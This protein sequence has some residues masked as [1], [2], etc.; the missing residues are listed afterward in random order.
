[1]KFPAPTS[2]LLPPGEPRMSKSS[3]VRI[4]CE[5]RGDNQKCHKEMEC[6]ICGNCAQH[7]PTHTKLK[8]FLPLSGPYLNQSG[9]KVDPTVGAK[10][11]SA[12]AQ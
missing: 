11:F 5:F 10:V 2:S 4:V 7:C 3:V 8:P 9:G 1:M 12:K 6:S